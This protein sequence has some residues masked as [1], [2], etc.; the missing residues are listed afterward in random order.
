MLHGAPFGLTR[1]FTSHGLVRSCCAPVSFP[2]SLTH[3]PATAHR[4]NTHSL[5]SLHR[6][7]PLPQVLGSTSRRP[8]EELARLCETGATLGTLTPEQ[9]RNI[10]DGTSVHRLEYLIGILRR[11]KLL[12]WAVVDP[13]RLEPSRRPGPGA[14]VRA[15]DGQGIRLLVHSRGGGA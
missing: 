14:A 8:R 2:L 6:R 4:H 13:S 1:S 11:L 3:L 7:P 12:E 15:R 10:M 9:A 5:T